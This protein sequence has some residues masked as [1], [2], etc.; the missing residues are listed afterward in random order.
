[1]TGEDDDSEKEDD[2]IKSDDNLVLVGRVDGDASI[3]EIF[4]LY[5]ISEFLFFDEETLIFTNDLSFQF[6]MKQKVHFI[7]IMTYCYHHSHCV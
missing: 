4:G 3:L 1:M 7:V 5:K 6:I 2:A